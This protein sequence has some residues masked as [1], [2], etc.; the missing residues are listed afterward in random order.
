MKREDLR[1]FGSSQLRQIETSD[2]RIS[3][4]KNVLDSYDFNAGYLDDDYSWSTCILALKAVSQGNFGVGSILVGSVGDVLEWGHN[5]VFNPY[6]RSDRHAEMVVVTQFEDLHRT[7]DEVGAFR[8]Y[9]SLEPCPMCLTR[10]IVS[11]IGTI[12]YAAG[13]ASGGMVH[14]MKKLPDEW[15]ILSTERVFAQANCSARLS[16]IAK[17]I[18]LLTVEELDRKLERRC[19]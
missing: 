9:S 7:A 12:K 2:N 19:I 4:W 5:E 13:D 3:F 15:L 1:D 16:E 18:F 11:G 17:E 14:I 8:L 6:F 10:L